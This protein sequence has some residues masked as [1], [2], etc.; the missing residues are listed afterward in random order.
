MNTEPVIGVICEQS[1]SVLVGRV[2]AA[3]YKAIRVSPAQLV[4][5]ELPVVD[6]WVV[7]C[8]DNSD[9]ADA[10]AWIETRVLA[11]SNR[12]DLSDLAEYR[13]WCDRIIR[14]LD[15]WNASFWQNTGEQSGSTSEGYADV[16]AVWILAASAGG[17]PAVSEFLAALTHVPPVAF[18]YAQHIEADQQD[19]LKAIGHVNRDIPCALAI[20][21]HWLNP[22]RILIAPATCQLRFT[23]WGEVFSTR[24]PWETR[25]TPHINQVMM[26]MSGL[27]PA[28][29]GAIIFSG[30]GTDGC[31]GLRALQAVGT[32]VW[33]QDPSTAVAPSMP[34]S[35]IDAGL[36]SRTGSAQ[37]L[38]AAMSE[39]YPAPA[40]S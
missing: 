29:G 15:K 2:R 7:D 31:A 39:L 18:I 38:A 28:P 26:A 36:V 35:A 5:D 32:R 33:A 24:E 9:V 25:E 4:P 3:G 13:N 12:P 17:V 8:P 37:D 14:T 6:A 19:L 10:M 30:T 40:T 22:G 27:Q 21:R 16:E 20:G 34:Q 23:N 11:L 1:T